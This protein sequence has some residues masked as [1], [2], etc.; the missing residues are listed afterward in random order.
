MV[1]QRILKTNKLKYV[2]EWIER[3]SNEKLTMITR[4]GYLKMQISLQKQKFILK[5]KTPT[6]HYNNT[7]I[8]PMF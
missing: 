2:E 5:Y 4:F 7:T 8:S 3:D 1:T 6:S